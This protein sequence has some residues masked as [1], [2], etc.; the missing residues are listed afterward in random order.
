MSVS[1]QTTLDVQVVVR[2]ALALII[3]LLIVMVIMFFV[4]IHYGF[5]SITGGAIPTNYS[6]THIVSSFWQFVVLLSYFFLQE[7]LY[8][9]TIGKRFMG[10]MV[11]TENG[12]RLSWRSAFLRNLLRYIDI[13]FF[14]LGG[15]L[16]LLKPRRQR[17]GDFVADTLVVRRS[18]VPATTQA[19]VA[20][21]GER[22]ASLICILALLGCAIYGYFTRPAQVIDEMR[23]T[24][25]SIFADTTMTHLAIGAPGW[26]GDRV[27][28]P[29]IYQSREDNLL[30]NCRG[31]IVIHYSLIWGWHDIS[32]SGAGCQAVR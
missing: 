14:L 18:S 23:L 25:Q 1:I 6:F 24:Q 31:Q 9:T 20:G 12:E 8:S 22:F 21:R 3:D 28:Y 26:Y 13:G 5:L 15:V 30:S 7:T 16:V 4:N 2:R 19:S 10:L 32:G 27:I 11:V 29:V 17:I